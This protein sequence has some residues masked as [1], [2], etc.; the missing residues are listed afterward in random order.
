MP[1]L[2]S[3]C[4]I[5]VLPLLALLL[6]A[7][8]ASAQARLPIFDAHIH[9]SQTAWQRFPPKAVLEVWN[10]AGIERAIVSST[11]D[12]GTVLLYEA[13]PQRVVAFLRP[14]RG[15]WGPSNWYQDPN[16][17]DYLRE[18]LAKGVHKGIGEFHLFDANAA[19]T[20]A[21]K[22]VVKLA[23]ERDLWLLVHSGAEAAGRLASIDPRAKVIWAHLGMSESAPV[24]DG[25]L[26]RFPTM[27]TE[28][29]F[30]DGDINGGSI[31]P[32]WKGLFLKYRDRIMVG[33]D[34]YVTERW[35]DCTRLSDEHRRWLSQLPP[36]VAE[37]L[38]WR[39]AARL[40]GTG[41]RPALEK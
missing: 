10:Q 15:Q 3:L 36:D 19:D 25:L 9:Y 23:V 7:D 24:V 39:N 4:R 18:R 13:A 2:R 17:L 37:R 16:L 34:T 6:L 1:M 31:D 32:A 14:Y 11:P 12:D 8:W 38:A 30:R 21:V 35:E 20:R 22:D 40:F 41:G 5:G 33:T 29:S 28:T 26:A 27:W